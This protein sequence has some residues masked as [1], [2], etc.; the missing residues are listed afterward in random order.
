MFQELKAALQETDENSTFIREMIQRQSTFFG[1]S[2]KRY[3]EENFVTTDK[4]NGKRANG[5]HPPG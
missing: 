2:M 1:H 5:R 4:V 3:N